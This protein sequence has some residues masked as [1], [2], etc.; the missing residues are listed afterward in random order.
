MR[1]AQAADIGSGD[2][3]LDVGCGFADHDMLWAKRLG[4]RQLVGVNVSAEQLAAAAR[5]YPDRKTT[6]VCLLVAD[7]VRLPFTNASFDAV[8]G[9]ESAFHFRTRKVFFA[10]ALRVLKPGGRLALADLCGVD[11]RLG[12]KD[13]LAEFFGR[14]FWKIP[15]EN[16][17]PRAEYARQLQ[18]AG[19][20]DISVSSIWHRVYPRF[21]DYARHR[22]HAPE[23]A[24]RMSPIF[25]RMLIASL[26]A[27]RKLDPEAMDYVLASAHKPTT[28]GRYR[29]VA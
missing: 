8:L 25:R 16:L 28:A 1:V 13:R 17:V 18:A 7:A 4:P 24:A 21:A 27:R 22:L 14:S 3:V 15:R 29:N 9:V 11:R 19:F 5:L 20:T 6:G 10:E 2:T 23:V 12:P 26:G